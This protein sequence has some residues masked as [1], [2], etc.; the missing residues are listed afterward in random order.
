MVNA[1]VTGKGNYTSEIHMVLGSE[2]IQRELI[3]Q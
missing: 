1:H 3:A 2:L